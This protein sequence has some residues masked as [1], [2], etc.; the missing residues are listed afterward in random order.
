MWNLNCLF[1]LRLECYGFHPI[2]YNFLI[3]LSFDKTSV[4]R[5]FMRYLW[6]FFLGFWRHWNASITRFRDQHSWIFIIQH[7]FPTLDNYNCPCYTF[8]DNETII[9]VPH[10]K[11][12]PLRDTTKSLPPFISVCSGV[13]TSSGLNREKLEKPP[14]NS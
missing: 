11:I 13:R 12:P 2:L 1:V 10:C 9:N 14:N 8:M 5:K 4:S 3:G 6:Y 7:F